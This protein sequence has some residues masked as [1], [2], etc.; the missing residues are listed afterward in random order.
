MIDFLKWIGTTILGCIAFV[1][2]A[3]IYMCFP[4]NK[5]HYEYVDLDNNNGV[6]K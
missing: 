3:L 4:Q 5:Y 2:F 1:I 6:A